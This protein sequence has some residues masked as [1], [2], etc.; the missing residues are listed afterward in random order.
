[1]RYRIGGSSNAKLEYHYSVKSDLSVGLPWSVWNKGQ[2]Q[3][4]PQSFTIF[5]DSY[6]YL[7]FW[8]Q[9]GVTSMHVFNYNLFLCIY[10]YPNSFMYVC[11]YM[12]V[13]IYNVYIFL[14]LYIY[15][16]L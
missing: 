9:E 13:Y 2:K 10:S 3:E 6:I 14:C 4:V 7:G 11:V 5:L 16:S 12:Y 1:M 8:S 15:F